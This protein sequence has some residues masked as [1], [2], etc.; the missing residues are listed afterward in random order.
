MHAR[1]LECN[2]FLPLDPKHHRERK[3]NRGR[4]KEEATLTNAPRSGLKGYKRRVDRMWW[5]KEAV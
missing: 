5:R 2:P 1:Q 4:E 3:N